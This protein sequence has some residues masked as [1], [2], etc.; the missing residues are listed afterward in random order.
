MA[1]IIYVNLSLY[2]LYP[3][4]YVMLAVAFCQLM[5]LSPVAAMIPTYLKIA[6]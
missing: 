3:R 1:V 6:A 4:E 2:N 5:Q